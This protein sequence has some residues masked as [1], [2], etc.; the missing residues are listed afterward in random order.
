MARPTPTQ[1][2]ERAEAVPQCGHGGVLRP[3]GQMRALILV[4]CLTLC[5]TLNKVVY[6]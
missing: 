3:R 5:P 1:S 2:L 6:V 4:R